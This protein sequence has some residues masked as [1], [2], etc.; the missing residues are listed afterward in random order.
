MKLG[1]RSPAI[2]PFIRVDCETI[3][4]GTK[5]HGVL[6]V[7][8]SWA[9]GRR[10]FPALHQ[11]VAER[12]DH[13]PVRVC[14][15]G[16]SGRN[17]AKIHTQFTAT[18][19]KAELLRLFDDQPPDNVVLLT[20]VNDIAQHIGASQ[21]SSFTKKLTD[22]LSFAPKIEVVTVPRVD[23]LGIRS[24]SK[25]GQI[26]WHIQRYLND[27]GEREVA[28]TY[29]ERLRRDHPEIATI[30]FDAFIPSFAGNEAFYMPD[31]MHLTPDGYQRYGA[32]I[33]SSI[34]LNT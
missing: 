16:L 8:E 3:G 17:S 13:G 32:F 19:P 6:V 20:G 33:G 10:L 24:P 11:A 22:H 9:V 23:E 2:L 34:S 30:D 21:Y 27:G 26:K 1:L 7:G 15:I 31:G 29:R 25:F 4:K 5:P 18:F 28:E 14:T 12:L